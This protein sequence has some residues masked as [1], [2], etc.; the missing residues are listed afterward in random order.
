MT[1]WF[2]STTRKVGEDVEW[3][4]STYDSEAEAKV[5]ASRELVRGFRIEAGTL[6]GVEPKRRIGWPSAHDWAQ[7][8]NDF[9]IM[10]LRRRL[11][12]LPLGVGRV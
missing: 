1:C 2:V 9:A 11:A 10:N 6:P 4:L 12:G 8:S 3:R 7:S 5:H